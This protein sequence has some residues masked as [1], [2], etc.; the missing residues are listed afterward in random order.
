MKIIGLFD[1]AR[2]FR[3]KIITDLTCCVELLRVIYFSDVDL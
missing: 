2:I 1:S 3:F